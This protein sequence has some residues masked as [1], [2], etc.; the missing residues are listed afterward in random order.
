MFWSLLILVT[1]LSPGT[2]EQSLKDAFSSFNGL[3]EGKPWILTFSFFSST[4]E[5]VLAFYLMLKPFKDVWLGLSRLSHHYT[6]N[7]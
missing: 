1:G 3:S 7:N 5:S 4:I 2:D 6:M